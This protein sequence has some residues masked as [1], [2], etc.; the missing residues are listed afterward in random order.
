VDDRRDA[1]AAPHHDNHD[2]DRRAPAMPEDVEPSMLAPEIRAELASLGRPL[3]ATV[4]RY[5]VM[6]GRLVDEDPELALAHARQARRFAARIG[7]VREAAGITAYHAGEWAEALTDLR[8]ARRLNGDVGQLP[9][10]ADCERA[11]GRP[12]RAIRVAHSDDAQQLGTAA[13]VELRIVEAGARRD[14]G[15]LDAALQVL[16]GGGAGLDRSRLF[17]WSVRLWYAYADTLL[18]AGQTEEATD[19]FLTVASVDADGQTDVEDRLADL[20][21]I[22]TIEEELDE[23]EEDSTPA[24]EE[25]YP[26]AEESPDQTGHPG[27]GVLAE[28]ALPPTEEPSRNETDRQAEMAP[29]SSQEAE[30]GIPAAVFDGPREDVAAV[31]QVPPPPV[32]GQLFQEPGASPRPS[33]VVPTPDKSA[34]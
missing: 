23:D 4:A 7:V 19:W 3:A 21:V 17:S 28:P 20:G 29:D 33:T 24:G 5:L 6:A 8:A 18:A 32:A 15:E 13:R 25:L 14:L 26:A 12:E 22:E 1:A 11:L 2:V 31:N 9:L 27:D 16:R 30:S 10:I 34:D